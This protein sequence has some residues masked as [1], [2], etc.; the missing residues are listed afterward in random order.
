MKMLNIND[1]DFINDLANELGVNPGE[2]IKII[3]PQFDR[4][5][6]FLDHLGDEILSD[7]YFW[8]RIVSMDQKQL[9][10][11]GCC[12][13]DDSG[14]MLF[15]YGWYDFIPDGFEMKCIDGST[16]L[17]ER[18]KTDNDYRFGCLAYGIIAK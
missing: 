7:P 18:G 5:D 10:N 6:G 16:E 13:W 14:L 1:A 2:E 15:P 11:L 12:L 4:T 8:S 9:E 3:T 17:M